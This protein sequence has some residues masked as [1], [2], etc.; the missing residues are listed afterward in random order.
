MD[1]C[2][3]RP[4]IVPAHHFAAV[5]A[6]FE[7]ALTA[8]VFLPHRVPRLMRFACRFMHRPASAAGHS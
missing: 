5:E 8:Q 4:A 7:P 3:S 2:G 6:K 1:G